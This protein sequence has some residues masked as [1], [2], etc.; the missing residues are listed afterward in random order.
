VYEILKTKSKRDRES[1]IIQVKLFQI[2]FIRQPARWSQFR[3]VYLLTAQL[4]CAI[5]K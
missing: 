1:Q 4:F 2:D 5:S 3:K